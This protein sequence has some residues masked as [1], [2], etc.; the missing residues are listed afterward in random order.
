MLIT[1]DIP[2]KVLAVASWLRS[3]MTQCQLERAEAMIEYAAYQCRC[4]YPVA[5]SQ[6][7]LKS[8]AQIRRLELAVM[9]DAEHLEYEREWAERYIMIED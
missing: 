3:C 5:L 7:Y 2:Q 8:I 1:H 9:P 4:E 6:Q